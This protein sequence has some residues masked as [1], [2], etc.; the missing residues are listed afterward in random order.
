MLFTGCEQASSVFSLARKLKRCH[1][2]SEI[3]NATCMEKQ[4]LKLQTQVSLLP[5]CQSRCQSRLVGW[6]VGKKLKS[7]KYFGPKNAEKSLYLPN[8]YSN[9]G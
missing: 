4:S 2:G 5:Y 3:C 9:D 7:I 6:T 1:N 8:P